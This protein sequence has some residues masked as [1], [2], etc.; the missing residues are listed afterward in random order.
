MIKGATKSGLEFEIDENRLNDMEVIDTLT[1]L[2]EADTDKS[3]LDLSKLSKLI[4]KVLTKDMKKK[5]YDHVR[6]EDG[7][8]PIDKVSEE[9]FEI[10]QYNGETKNS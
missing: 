5:L 1:E 6:T 8:S 9:F 4:S 3:N 7:R 10:L 2:S